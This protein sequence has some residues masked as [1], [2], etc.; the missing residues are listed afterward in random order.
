MNRKERRAA[1]K[2]DRRN[3]IAASSPDRAAKIDSLVS[4]A[5][6]LYQENQFERARDICRQAVALDASHAVANNLLGVVFQALGRDKIA[7]QHFAKAIES[8]DANAL[9]HYNIGFSYQRLNSWDDAVAHF[10]RA[11]A[12]K[13][14]G[15]PVEDFVKQYPPVTSCLN[16][17]AQQW[18]RRLTIDLLFGA[19]GV[20]AVAEDAFLRC[21]LEKTEFCSL[22]LEE[23]LSSVRFALLQLA[24][25]AAPEFG[26]IGDKDLGFYAALAQQCFIN[27]YLLVQS[28]D[29][30]RQAEGLRSLMLDRLAS[31][32]TIPPLLLIAVA[33][34]FPLHLLPEAA[35]LRARDWPPVVNGVLRQHLI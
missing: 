30:T 11:L 26:G 33:A 29:E 24:A 18:P 32:G 34:Y 17:I 4:E 16:R 10:S 9:F 13:M 25:N 23:F 2:T 6:R 7:I 1:L 27:E 5:G 22:E 31:G 28:D 35:A 14:G 3:A 19:E 8:D 20:A 15:K 12:L 21:A